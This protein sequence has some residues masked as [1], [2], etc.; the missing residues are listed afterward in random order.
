MINKKIYFI[1]DAHLGAKTIQNPHE[2]EKKLTRWLD[3]IKEDA[4]AIYLMGDMIDFWFEYKNVVP[5]GFTRFFGKLAELSDLGIEVHWF[6]GN[7]DIWIFDYIP[8]EIGVIIHKGP[9]KAEILGKTFFLAHGDGL[10]D[11]SISDKIT[12]SLFHSRICQW[13]LATVHPRW[14]IG[15]ALAWSRHSRETGENAQYRGEDNEFLVVFSK[16]YL[17]ENP[18]INYFIYGHRHIILNL[19][20]AKDSNVII[21]GDWITHFSYAVF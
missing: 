4:S 15:F 17:K 14:T 21:L 2:Q 20:I 3:S 6:I 13:M 8:N 7:H 18:D 9:E 11:K 16:K 12:R 1:S 19:M 10:A 5:R